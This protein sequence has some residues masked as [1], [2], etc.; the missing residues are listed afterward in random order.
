MGLELKSQPMIRMGLMLQPEMGPELKPMAKIL[1]KEQP[2]LGLE[3]KMWAKWGQH[4][5]WSSG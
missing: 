2:K 3:P 4:L 5:R 1:A